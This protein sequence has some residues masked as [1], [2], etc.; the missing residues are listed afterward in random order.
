MK[1]LRYTGRRLP[2]VDLAPPPPPMLFANLRLW[3]EPLIHLSK[4]SQNI[5]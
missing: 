5:H 4:E 2:M 1:N 3:L